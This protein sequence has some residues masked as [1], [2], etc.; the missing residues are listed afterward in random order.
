ML[1]CGST[2][3]EIFRVLVHVKV[4]AKLGVGAFFGDWTVLFVQA[5]RRRCDSLLL[6]VLHLLKRWGKLPLKFAFR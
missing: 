6:Y 3:A 2:Y 1:Q 4:F 5:T